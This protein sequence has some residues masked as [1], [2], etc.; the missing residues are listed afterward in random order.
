MHYENCIIKMALLSMKRSVIRKSIGG[1]EPINLYDVVEKYSCDSD[2]K[3]C[4]KSNHVDVITYRDWQ[5]VEFQKLI[6]PR[7]LIQQ[8]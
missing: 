3:E 8:F 5:F 1:N 2:Y 6:L 4:T 7:A